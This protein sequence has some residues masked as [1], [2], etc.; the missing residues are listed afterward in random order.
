MDPTAFSSAAAL[1]LA[2]ID[3]ARALGLEAQIGSLEAG[4]RADIVVIDTTGPAWT[5]HADDPTLALVW[6]SD[7]RAVRDVVASGQ[8]VV[9][10]GTCVTVDHRT[11]A[12]EA[13]Q[14][15]QLLVSK[16]GAH[17]RNE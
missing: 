9:A 8:V 10:G 12:S 17:P 3:G 7:G 14:A 11:L 6:A 16:C 1:R 2:T 15:H 5:P 4:K 13:R